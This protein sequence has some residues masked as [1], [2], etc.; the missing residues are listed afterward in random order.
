MTA[1]E[2]VAKD[3]TETEVPDSTE[4]VVKDATEA[5]AKLSSAPT[6]RPRIRKALKPVKRRAESPLRP[7][8]NNSVD[9]IKDATKSRF[10]NYKIPKKTHKDVEVSPIA[11]EKA[12]EKKL[13]G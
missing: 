9:S 7:I 4:A 8:S 10:L 2:A 6:K 5:I 13:F 3:A 12:I 11:V 1:P